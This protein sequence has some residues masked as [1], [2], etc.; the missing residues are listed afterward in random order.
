M[1]DKE[2]SK[3]ISVP[4]CSILDFFSAVLPGISFPIGFAAPP[5]PQFLLGSQ[6]PRP[7]GLVTA[8]VWPPYQGS[9]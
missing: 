4:K 9:F 8:P 3:T 6:L 5:S 2:T 1:T 7:L